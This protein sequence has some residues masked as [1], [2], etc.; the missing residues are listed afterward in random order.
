VPGAHTIPA[1]SDVNL[2]TLGLDALRATVRLYA[3]REGLA[4]R[5]QPAPEGGLHALLAREE[6]DGE[7]YFAVAPAGAAYL[8]LSLVLVVDEAFFRENSKMI[9]DVTSRYEAC[10]TLSGDEALEAGEVYLNLSLRVFLDG[11]T[12]RVFGL[13]L[14]NLS[15]AKDALAEEFP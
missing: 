10:V 1:M 6:G 5:E 7:V 4:C 11:L 8:S 2:E 14:A 9:L 13:A 15:A 12:R 3:A